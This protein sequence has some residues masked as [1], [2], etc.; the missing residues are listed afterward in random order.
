MYLR[1]TGPL[2]V[3]VRVF[4]ICSRVCIGAKVVVSLAETDTDDN[5]LPCLGKCIIL[6]GWLV[7]VPPQLPLSSRGL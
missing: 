5:N 6:S 4:C 2:S 3:T 1:Q 7:V